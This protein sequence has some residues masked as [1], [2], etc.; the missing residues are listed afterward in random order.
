M[1]M[2]IRNNERSQQK[3]QVEITMG[4]S[5]YKIILNV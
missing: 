5:I 1:V 4:N 2:T 3:K